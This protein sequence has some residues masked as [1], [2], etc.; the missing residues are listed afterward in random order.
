[1]KGTFFTVAVLAL[2]TGCDGARELAAKVAGD[3]KPTTLAIRSGYQVQIDGRAVPIYGTSACPPAD[4][5]TH[6]LF[7]P[8]PDEKN[9]T[10]VVVG[11][12]TK[13]VTVLVGSGATPQPETWLVDHDG[14]KTTL[15]RPDGS[16]IVAA[17]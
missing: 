2:L 17:K 11:P 6:T 10:C 5:L 16:Y 3:G 12:D 1:M 14:S 8:G 13:A 15:R 4:E 9:S 7:G